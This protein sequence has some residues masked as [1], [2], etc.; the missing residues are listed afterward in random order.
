MAQN[1]I[2]TLNTQ[3]TDNVTLDLMVPEEKFKDFCTQITEATSGRA[4]MVSE[5]LGEFG[6]VD[7]EIIF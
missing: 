1:Q 4:I 5:D 2:F 7:G 6:I 3:Y